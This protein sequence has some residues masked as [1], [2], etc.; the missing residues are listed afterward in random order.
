MNVNKQLHFFVYTLPLR[1]TQVVS[2]LQNDFIT[3]DVF[4]FPYIT[5]ITLLSTVEPSQYIHVTIIHWNPKPRWQFSF[6]LV[7]KVWPRHASEKKDGCLLQ[8]HQLCRVSKRSRLLLVG[9]AWV[10]LSR[11][12]FLHHPPSSSSSLPPGSFIPRWP[13]ATFPHLF[14]FSQFVFR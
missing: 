10:L 11:S 12:P 8:F 6:V 1:Y 5:Y 4:F 2:S 13:V 7:H 3:V 9:S 14:P